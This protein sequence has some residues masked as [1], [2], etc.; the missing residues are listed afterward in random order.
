MVLLPGSVVNRTA[1]Q[2]QGSF[3]FMPLIART[4]DGSV[5]KNGSIIFN[6]EK[7]ELRCEYEAVD[8]IDVTDGGSL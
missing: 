2:F 8:R 5:L 4:G 1:D 3:L 6:I 7:N